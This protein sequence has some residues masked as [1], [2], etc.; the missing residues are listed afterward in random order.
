MLPTNRPPEDVSPKFAQTLTRV[1]GN[2]SWKNLYQEIPQ[3]FNEESR[4][5][6]VSGVNNLIG[7]YK[8]RLRELFG[9]RFLDQSKTLR[10][11]RN[12]P[13]YDLVFCVGSDAP[14]AIGLAKPIVEHLLDRVNGL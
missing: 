8:D 5:E 7:I 3:L 1:Y 12:S 4:F 2:D 9:E 13:L 11:S 6:R 10:N 14:A